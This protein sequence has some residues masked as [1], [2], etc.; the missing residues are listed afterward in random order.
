MATVE[1][2]QSRLD[3]ARKNLE[4]LENKLERINKAES[5]DW[6]VNPYYY[7]ESDK[8][9]TLKEI[10]LAKKSIEKYEAD[11]QSTVEKDNSRDVPA[12]LEFLENWKQRVFTTYEEIIKAYFEAKKE[13]RRLYEVFCKTGNVYDTT[14]AEYLAYDSARI[15]LY[16]KIKGYYEERPF[17]NRWGESDKKDVKVREGEWEVAKAYINQVSYDDAIKH[18]NK[19]IAEEAKRKYDFI[20]ERVN[21]ICGQITDASN[22]K[23]GAKG[24]LNGIIVGTKGSASLSTIG[25]GGYAV[26][27]FHYRTL[28]HKI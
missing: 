11:I 24:D 20:I 19:D 15:A 27:I 17:T 13:V 12:I 25:A 8:L 7:D 21:S 14:S 9:Y 26:Q 2:I 16:S 22:L 5:T 6:K 3:S 28:I 4:K 23:V 10:E 1:Y 18:L